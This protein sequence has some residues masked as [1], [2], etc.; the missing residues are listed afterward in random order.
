LLCRLHAIGACVLA[1]GACTSS[2]RPDADPRLC[3]QTYEFGN[4]GC[5]DITGQV[6]GSASQPLPNISVGPRY[7]RDR[8]DFNSPF[9]R[10]GAD[11]R[12]RLRLHR[13]GAP[14]PVGPDTVSFYLHAVD[15]NRPVT[16]K[17]SVM[18]QVTVAPVGARAP[19]TS[20]V[21]RLQSP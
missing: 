1:L 9:T 21:L 14:P 19:V 6:L 17:D 10:T 3:E 13:Y 7:L 11:G 12:F 20:V 18:I 5:V 15:F 16:G 8:D 2:T 4:Y